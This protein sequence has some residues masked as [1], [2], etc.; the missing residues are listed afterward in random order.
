M[1]ALSALTPHAG[2]SHDWNRFYNILECDWADPDMTC[3]RWPS[4]NR[5]AVTIYNET[6]IS[7]AFLTR[8][9][10]GAKTWDNQGQSLN[11]TRIGAVTSM[12][13]DECAS[14]HYNKNIVY[15]SPID[16]VGDTAAYVRACISGSL[17]GTVLRYVMKFDSQEPWYT[18]SD[19]NVPNTQVDVQSVATHEFGHAGGWGPHFDDAAPNTGIC[20]LTSTQETMCVTEQVGTSKGRTLEPHERAVFGVAY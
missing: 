6:N 18:G 11:F 3:G 7:G 5:G 2:A 8:V 20:Q 10:D 14:T 16:G 4:S 12:T 15:Q 17:N 1:V 13:H 9:L 19:P